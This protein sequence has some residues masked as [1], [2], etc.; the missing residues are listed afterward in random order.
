MLIL[1]FATS[2]KNTVSTFVVDATGTEN[3]LKQLTIE[4]NT[5]IYRVCVEFHRPCSCCRQQIL[6]LIDS[7][8]LHRRALLLTTRLP[9]VSVQL[10]DHMYV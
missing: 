8:L 7:H 6:Q 2:T 9:S 3:V 10:Q 4:L 5:K 1:V